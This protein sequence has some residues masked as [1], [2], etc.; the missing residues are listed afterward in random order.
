MPRLFAIL[1]TGVLGHLPFAAELAVESVG[2]APFPQ[3]LRAV[4]ALDTLPHKAQAR[5]LPGVSGG[6]LTNRL[7][8]RAAG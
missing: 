2:M 3:D 7:V 8:H 4:H 1:S 5:K 6:G